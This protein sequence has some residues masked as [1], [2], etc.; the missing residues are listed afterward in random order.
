[1]LFPYRDEA[2]IKT[3]QLVIASKRFLVSINFLKVLQ[4]SPK[5]LL[6]YAFHHLAQ[7]II[8]K[9][10]FINPTFR[11]HYSQHQNLNN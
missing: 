10:I 4:F 8:Q 6:F 7:L 5:I 9:L 1:M 3:R 2:F 11:S